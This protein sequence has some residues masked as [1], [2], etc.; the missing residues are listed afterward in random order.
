M[1]VKDIDDRVTPSRRS[2]RRP[3][4]GQRPMFGRLPW[5]ALERRS[6]DLRFFVFLDIG[7]EATGHEDG[8]AKQPPSRLTAQ[9]ARVQA[10]SSSAGHVFTTRSSGTSLAAAISHP[11]GCHSS[12]PVAWASESIET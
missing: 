12:W 6:L 5:L 10:N 8:P 9:A 1:A 4:T 2:G 3:R 11:C 7:V